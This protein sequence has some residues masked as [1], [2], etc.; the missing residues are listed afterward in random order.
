MNIRKATPEDANSFLMFLKQLDTET[1]FM[2]FEPEERKTTPE[3]MVKRIEETNRASLLLLAEED[4]KIVGFLS[5][6]RGF[7]NRIKHTAYIVVGILADNIGMGLGKR[8]FEKLDIWA[9]ESG[10]IR[11]EL[12]VMVPNERAIKLYSSMGFKIEGTRGKACLVDGEFID[13]Y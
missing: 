2:L 4:G 5:A 11:L 1:S 13:E 6:E 7:A 10:V 12:T 3:A 9:I 8:L